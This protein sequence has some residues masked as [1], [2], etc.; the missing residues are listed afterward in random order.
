MVSPPLKNISQSGSFPQAGVNIKNIWNHNLILAWHFR[1]ESIIR[2]SRHWP[3]SL[4]KNLT[5]SFWWVKSRC[6]S[7]K[8]I[9]KNIW[10]SM[11]GPNLGESKWDKMPRQLW[12]LH[13]VK[14]T[15]SKWMWKR[16]Q[17]ILLAG[18]IYIYIMYINQE[19]QLAM[20]I[21]QF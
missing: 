18:Y 9:N 14:S 4:T 11:T 12:N 13:P 1:D 15:A 19:K 17:V 7:T 16:F 8:N 6:F 2:L 10:V 21:T 3:E 20:N 5:N